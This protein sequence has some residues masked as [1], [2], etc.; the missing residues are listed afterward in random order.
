MAA[1]A[2]PGRAPRA[3]QS[4]SLYAEEDSGDETEKEI[5]RPAK[6][7]GSRKRLSE[8]QDQSFSEDAPQGRAPLRTVNINDDVAEKRRRR[9]SAKVAVADDSEPGSSRPGADGQV[10]EGSR[11]AQARQ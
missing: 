8:A 7:H 10:A 1:T 5:S 6:G 2:R 3:Q 4:Q 11:T 9:K